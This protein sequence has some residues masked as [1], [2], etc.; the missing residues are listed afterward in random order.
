M[1]TEAS[2]LIDIG[3]TSLKAA[4]LE[5]DGTLVELESVPTPASTAGAGRHETDPMAFVAAVRGV[6]ERATMQYP[7]VSAVALSTQ[8][9]GAVVTNGAN[10]PLSPYFSWQDARAAEP[11]D[12]GLSAI[13]KVER[14]LS[15]AEVRALGVPAR[16][17]LGAYTVS[18]WAEDNPI[19]SGSRLHTLGSFVA[20]SLG[21]P[22]VTHVTNA[23]PLG[24]LDL[25]RST[26][27]AAALD[28][29]GLS[30][31]R[32]PK[33]QVPFAP[34]GRLEDCSAP[35][36]LYPDVGDHQASLLASAVDGH[37]L[38]VSLGTAGIA[39]RVRPTGTI[40]ENGVEVRPYF[41]DRQLHV[42]SRLPG[43]KLAQDW[44]MSAGAPP[45]AR[46]WDHA[47]KSA[48]RDPGGPEAAFFARYTSAYKT[49]VAELFPH[50]FPR[51]VVLNGGVAQNIPW[52]THDFA[53][54]LGIADAVRP[55][56]DLSLRGLATLMMK[57]RTAP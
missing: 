57:D 44:Y 51:K 32:L 55:Q 9:H 24:V 3:S 2:L 35:L 54:S 10:V 29:L 27:S 18:R 22:Y 15:T 17:G 33:V 30:H 20:C 26:W 34:I 37:D 14:A 13:E 42:R 52:F 11:A 40:P 43:G 45:I 1:T 56:G 8:M 4:V 49:A 23:A 50:D 53:A 39:A 16:V 19:P 21:G 28:A 48:Q 46:F 41:D 36:T 7:S 38:A 31:V 5:P 25:A 12:D 47:S 6:I